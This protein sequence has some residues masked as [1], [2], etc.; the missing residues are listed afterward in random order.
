MATINE[1][2]ERNTTDPRARLEVGQE[3]LAAFDRMR[4]P[5]D[6]TVIT[7][8]CDLIVQWLNGSNFKVGLLALEILDAAL[9][10]SGDVLYPYL[11]ENV[12]ALMERLG[13]SKEQV[14]QSALDV[15]LK[16]MRVPHS[17]P[18]M[19]FERMLGGFTHKQWLVRVGVMQVL[20]NILRTFGGNCLQL[21]KVVPFIC[22]LIADPNIQVR[23]TAV[24]TLVEIYVYTGDRFIADLQRRRLIPDQKMSTILQRFQDAKRAGLVGE[25]GEPA[26]K[27]P[28]QP[29]P[30][31]TNA[32]T[33]QRRPPSSGM[34][35]GRVRM[36][37]NNMSE[38]NE[39]QENVNTSAPGSTKG[40]WSR[41]SSVPAHKRMT[42]TARYA[43]SAGAV[44][45]EQFEKAFTD[46]P[47]LEIYSAKELIANMQQVRDSLSDPN[48]DWNKRVDSLKKLR[49]ILIGGAT[50]FSE[51][52]TE[53]KLLEVPL[54]L[55]VKDLRSQVVREACI[56]IAL[57]AERLELKLERLVEAVFHVLI[58]LIQN[59]AKV[60]ATSGL[61]ACRYIIQSVRTPKLIPIVTS[62]INSKSREIRR[63]CCDF[64]TL[65]LANWEPH[66]VERNIP[67]LVDAIKQGLNDAD[68]DARACS[69]KAYHALADNFK[70]HADL[71]FQSLDASKQRQLAGEMS[72]SSSSQSIGGVRRSQE[73]L[74]GRGVSSG[75]G[76]Q[77]GVYYG[78]RSTS[79]IDTGAARRAMQRHLPPGA[80][81]KPPLQ[82]MNALQRPQRL[83]VATTGTPRT[84]ALRSV[85][86]TTPN[87]NSARTPSK[88]ISQPGSRSGSPTSRLPM[89]VRKPRVSV[90]GRSTQ[91]SREQS[92]TRTPYARRL[93]TENS[94]NITPNREME[95]ALLDALK[96]RGNG[97]GYLDDFD[98]NSSQ[99]SERSLNR[100]ESVELGEAIRLCQSTQW[101]DKKDGLTALQNF[102]RSNKPLTSTELK[103]LCESF[104]RM[105]VEQHNKTFS[106]FLDTLV[107][108]L[109]GYRS[110]LCDWLYVLLT[111][112]LTKSGNELLPSVSSKV[113]KTLDVVRES[114]PYDLQFNTLSRY[115]QD[116]VHT[117]SL[118]VKVALLE[119][120]HDLLLRMDSGAFSNTAEVRQAVSKIISWVNEPKS[121]DVRRVSQEVL[122]AMFSL[123]AS[124][125]STI[126]ATF[127]KPSQ[128]IVYTLLKSN[129]KRQSVGGGNMARPQPPSSGAYGG[130]ALDMGQVHD[131]LRET[132]AQIN[133]YVFGRSGEVEKA[134]GGS[135]DSGIVDAADGFARGDDNNIRMNMMDTFQ[136]TADED[137]QEEIIADIC[138]ELSN[139][140][141]RSLERCK[142]M[143]TLKH[144][145]RDGSFTL[146]DE[147]FKT[148][149]LLLI[150][151]LGDSDFEIRSQALRV[152]K[153]IC[154]S[155]A[156]RFR[157]YAELT[158]MRV[159]EAHKDGEKEVV[160]S[161]EE[162]ASVLATHLPPH[163]CLRVLNPVISNEG[164]PKLLAA[165]KM[166]TRV[167][168]LLSPDEI[169]RILPDVVPGVVSAFE[170]QDSSVRK[171]SCLCLVSLHNS[172]GEEP[173]QPFLS[174]LNSSKV[175]LLHLYI[176]RAQTSSGH[177]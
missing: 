81:V 8:F 109:A 83:S 16:L 142:S 143:A 47:K 43:G 89:S 129:V 51:F 34:P 123:N 169:E 71:L 77:R 22:K 90:S 36:N 11:L 17:S 100:L 134:K 92:P 148:I 168:E 132:S 12:T 29:P 163:V 156:A 7:N 136:L 25:D 107:D 55:A 103:R 139:H 38:A 165:I 85:D 118:K 138:Q 135:Q 26:V 32:R 76:A 53:L 93:S 171:A 177:I 33:P 63:T 147:H 125:F 74:A 67:L 176:K 166:I 1:L 111:R 95:R 110:D 31:P 86:S 152:L 35:S 20:Q 151:T 70:D 106:L 44:S 175:K 164:M 21:S 57:Y 121:A 146:W 64:I 13:D 117:P 159:L 75:Y 96:V 54:Q 130:T 50:N 59:S 105:F 28:D 150:E 23:D 18:Q 68:P 78:G 80:R 88:S 24:D 131:R 39:E 15:I 69:R 161:A 104:A 140:N 48:N 155:Q 42:V 116:P 167:I 5:S 157:D 30:P 2:L 40:G 160:R 120:L 4:L 19:I 122:V 60:M 45:E 10:V 98:D 173:L 115:I 124:A 113:Q 94:R 162:C 72:Q 79:D 62:H 108:F 52:Q 128:D 144:M 101:A 170:S 65:I 102:F 141:R 119:Y 172:I 149:L 49:S 6:S 126:L 84:T 61:V 87:H 114:F 154:L 97:G 58:N 14:R 112:L 73:N 99:C 37:S 145:A 82:P 127:P 46:V 91:G 158:V 137:R 56:S 27:I 66:T 41:A 133:Q 3:L 153:E 174:L 9:E